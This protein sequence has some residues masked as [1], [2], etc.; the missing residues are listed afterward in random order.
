MWGSNGASVSVDY[1]NVRSGK[2]PYSVRYN[3]TSVTNTF[4]CIITVG[5]SVLTQDS[6]VLWSIVHE[7]GHLEPYTWAR[8]F[9]MNY[10]SGIMTLVFGAGATDDLSANTGVSGSVNYQIL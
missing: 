3:V 7:D 5:T 1:T 2:I 4:T 9:D 6:L 10:G 8:S